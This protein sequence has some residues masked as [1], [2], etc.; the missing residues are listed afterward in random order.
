ME[1]QTKHT[2]QKIT[3]KRIVALLLLLV[4]LGLLIAGVWIYLDRTN[5]G[6]ESFKTFTLQLDGK[7]ISTEQTASCMEP[8][9]HTAKTDYLFENSAEK[10]YGFNVTIKPKNGVKFNFTV[11]EKTY[12]WSS[13]TKLDAA[14]SLNKE[15]SSFTFTVPE[16]LSEVL[17][18]IHEG[19][20][21]LP[22]ELP[23]DG[24]IYSLV[25]SSY[26]GKIV[27]TVDFSINVP[28][29]GVAVRPGG[30]YL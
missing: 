14:F 21:G 20:I 27:Y 28:A 24:C 2:P 18:K 12:A 9:V 26:N 6:T 10:S 19:E 3:A 16:N 23:D 17:G 5:S 15:G 13:E 25:V 22:S 8:G 11:D 7:R 4:V 29:D 30:I 1:K